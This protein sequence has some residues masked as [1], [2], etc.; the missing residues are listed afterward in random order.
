MDAVDTK[1]KRFLNLATSSAEESAALNAA[2]RIPPAVAEPDR[3]LASMLRCSLDDARGNL[4][5]REHLEHLARDA[6]RVAAIVRTL[7]A[8]HA[9]VRDLSRLVAGTRI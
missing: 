3:N 1:P 9:L 6:D 7:G 5:I 4:K 2:S 8:R